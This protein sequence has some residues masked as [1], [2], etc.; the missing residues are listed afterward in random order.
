M[1]RANLKAGTLYT[2]GK[3]AQRRL[4]DFGPQYK[5]YAEQADDDCLAY[6]IV[7]GPLQTTWQGKTDAGEQIQHA[8]A[9][10]FAQWAK[11]E[12]TQ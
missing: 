1:K 11:S 3:G 12:V 9:K 2:N 5:L 4:L 7:Q 10:S 6:S 8:T